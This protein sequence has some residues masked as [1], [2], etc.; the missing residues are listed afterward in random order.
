[1][2]IIIIVL[3]II[4]IYFLLP[5][6]EKILEK[7]LNKA[8]EKHCP[9]IEYLKCQNKEEFKKELNNITKDSSYLMQKGPA[10]EDC[11]NILQLLSI[12]EEMKENKC[13][14]KEILELTQKAI[15]LK[16]HFLNSQKIKKNI[17]YLRNDLLRNAMLCK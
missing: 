3:I 7:R 8:I 12:I 6:V 15:N 17:L 4:G 16:F 14:S 5:N 2:K 9:D 11:N 1:M 10:Y 13:N